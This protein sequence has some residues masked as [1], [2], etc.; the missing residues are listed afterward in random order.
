MS[1]YMNERMSK[2]PN[3]KVGNQT[4]HVCKPYLYNN[5]SISVRPCVCPNAIS[6]HIY[7]Q[8]WTLKVPMEF[9]GQGGP[10]K[11][12][13]KVMGPETKKKYYWRHFF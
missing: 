7:G 5:L 10:N 11:T 3:V 4:N 6:S 8:I 1:P 13:F 12:I 2:C 9:L